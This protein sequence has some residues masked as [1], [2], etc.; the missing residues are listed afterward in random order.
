[1][2]SYGVVR[3]VQSA[4]NKQYG[5]LWTYKG[6]ARKHEVTDTF[7]ASQ[8]FAIKTSRRLKDIEVEIWCGGDLVERYK[9]GARVPLY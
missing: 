7:E 9:N 2:E 1:M 8:V 4:M 6:G 3:A 5:V